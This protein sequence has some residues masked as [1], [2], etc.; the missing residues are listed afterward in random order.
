MQNMPYRS[1]NAYYRELFGCKVAKIS[2]EGGFSCPN[3]DGTLGQKGCIF[4]STHGSGDFAEDASLS[5]R[6][7]IEKGK[8]QT[9]KKWDSITSY[10]AYFQ[11][12]TNTYAPVDVLRQKYEE[13]L[14]Q[15]DIVGISIAT[16]PDCL[17]DDV[18]DL[19]EELSKKTTL[20]VELGLQTSNDATGALINRGYDNA[21]FVSAVQR[22]HRRGILVVA[23]VILGLPGENAQDAR[24]TIHF[25]NNLPIHGI[26]LHLLHVLEHTRL[27]ELYLSGEYIPLEKQEYL[28]L[29]CCCIQL[30]RE[31]IV[32]HRLT[33]DGDKNTLLAP[34][35]SLHKR[36]VLNSLHKMLRNGDVCQGEIKIP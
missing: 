9:S 1:L 33:G 3:R 22:L 29:L 16:R 6:E 25:L 13:A 7:Q 17:D 2:I 27:A 24:N 30:L 21:V 18:L 8:S 20:W 36:D 28:E 32:I 11:A 31:D 12:F 14:S 5:I 23:H 10:I 15:P 4:C 35:W 26:K 34:K 19:L